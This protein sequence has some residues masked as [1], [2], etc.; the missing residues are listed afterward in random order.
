MVGFEESQGEAQ[1]R[2]RKT[3]QL[4]AARMLLI[5]ETLCRMFGMRQLCG[6]FG[7]SGAN[8]ISERCDEDVRLPSP[9]LV[10]IWCDHDSN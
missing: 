6:V 10:Y 4:L 2:R 5:E 3:T 1:L 8:V 7:C 9:M